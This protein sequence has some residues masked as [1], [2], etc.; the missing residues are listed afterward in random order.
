MLIDFIDPRKMIHE[1]KNEHCH[2]KCCVLCI[3]R[4]ASSDLG[5]SVEDDTYF[6]YSKNA[7]CSYISEK[8]DM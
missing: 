4:D 2:G 3:R 5:M 8:G 6:K 7:Y 1:S